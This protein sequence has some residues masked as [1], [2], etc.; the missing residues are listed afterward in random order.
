MIYKICIKPDYPG[1]ESVYRTYT[2]IASLG[3]MGVQLRAPLKHL[4]TI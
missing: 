4:N 1:N 2:D 3:R